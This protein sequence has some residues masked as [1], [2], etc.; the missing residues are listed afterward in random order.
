[1]VTIPGQVMKLSAEDRRWALAVK[2]R[3]SWTCQ[4]CGASHI[5]GSK[6]LNAHHVFTRSRKATRYMLA[7]GISVCVGCHRWVH[8]N[9]YLARPFLEKIVPEFAELEQLSRTL[10]KGRT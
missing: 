4:R 7:N 8:A 9:P 2:E 3:E 5:P 1:M 6:G 10:K